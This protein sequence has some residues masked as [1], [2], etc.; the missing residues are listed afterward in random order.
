MTK[1]YLSLG[2]NM[3]D[4][5][6]Y[7]KEAIHQLEQLPHTHLDKV[8]AIYETVAWGKTDQ[9]NFLNLA[10]CFE[11]ELEPITFL[12]HIH[13]IEKNL[14]RVRHEKWGPRTIDIDI[15]LFGQVICKTQDLTIPHPFMTQRAF[16]LIP[17]LEINPDLKLQGENRSLSGYLSELPQDDIKNVVKVS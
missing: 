9:D 15:L 12:N 3:G 2:S 13:I 17:L 11:T 14:G 5:K 7:L 6:S 1:I 10:A 16:V 8:S 4:R